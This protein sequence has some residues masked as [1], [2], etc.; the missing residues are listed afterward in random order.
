V[1]G[2][3]QVKPVQAK[4]DNIVNLPTPQNKRQLM[5]YLGMIGYYRKFCKNFSSVVSPLTNL[6]CKG[7]KFRWCDEC[8]IAF[9]KVK[10]MLMNHP[11]L[12]APDFT[13]EFILS[14]DAS[15]IGAGAVLQQKDSEGIMHPVCYYSKKFNCCQKKYSTVEKETL[16]LLL[17]LNH[18]EVYLC[19][20]PYPI[21]VYTDSNPLTFI[22]KMKCKNQKIAR[23]SLVLQEYNLV[24][25]HIKGTANVIA[26]ALSRA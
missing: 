9:D 8:Q 1:V 25:E 18:F 17:A 13:K 5:R 14:I 16:S 4:V 23:W 11:I 19:N 3:G 20:A 12:L 15:D 22:E 24:I 7:V 6:L 21:T 2:K 10:A 26:D